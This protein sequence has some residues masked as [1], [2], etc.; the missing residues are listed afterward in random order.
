MAKALVFGMVAAIVAATGHERR[1]WS[2]ELADA[3]DESV[4]PSSMPLFVINFATSA[5]DFQLIPPKT[6]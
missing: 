5:I 4:A 2:Q 3:V 6:G 1:A